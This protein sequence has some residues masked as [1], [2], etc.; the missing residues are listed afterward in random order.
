MAFGL[1]NRPGFD[2]AF[3]FLV[4]ASLTAIAIII[5]WLFRLKRN[6]RCL[7]LGLSLILGGAVGNLID[8]LRLREVI[9]FL[10]F[11]VGPYHWHTFN[12]A[13]S[14]I[15]VGTFL[16]AIMLVFGTKKRNQMVES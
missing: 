4:I 15:T 13:D 1:M 16:V 12:I 14:G 10:D 2:F 8:R 6:D 9:D 5:I 3:Y 7:T 11:F